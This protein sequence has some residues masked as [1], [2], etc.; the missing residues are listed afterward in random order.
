MQGGLGGMAGGMGGQYPQQQ[1]QQ[2]LPQPPPLPTQQPDQ[3]QQMN[4]AAGG[5]YSGYPT[6][7]CVCVFVCVEGGYGC[8]LSVRGVMWVNGKR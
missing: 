5:Q 4:Y 2:Q 8:G 6:Q 3:Q 1:Q 7:V